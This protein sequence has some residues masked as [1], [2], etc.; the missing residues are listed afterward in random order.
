MK[1]ICIENQ[2]EHCRFNL[3]IGKEYEVSM[4][5]TKKDFYFIEYKETLYSK[6]IS[7]GYPKDLFITQEEI[8]NQ[9]LEE[10]GI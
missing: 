5:P 2:I 4:N 1:A 10:L 9:K 6:A 8:R 3:S 7:L